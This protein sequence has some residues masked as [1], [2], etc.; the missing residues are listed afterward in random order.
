MVQ[1]SLG[2]A[3]RFFNEK[4]HEVR[5]KARETTYNIDSWSP[6]EQTAYDLDTV[7]F[8]RKAKDSTFIQDP[9]MDSEGSAKRGSDLRDHPIR[10]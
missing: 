6:Q 7:S 4:Y 5:R 8:D 9:P 10:D 2:N 3:G 1:K